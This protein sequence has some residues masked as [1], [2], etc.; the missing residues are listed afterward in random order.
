MADHPNVT[1]LRQG[2]EAFAKKDM[3]TLATLFSPDVVWHWTGKGPLAGIHRG[4]DAVFG[5]FGRMAMLC[6]DFRNHV[7]DI[8]ANDQHAV[9]LTQATGTRPGK[10]LDLKNVM[11]F[12]VQNEKVSEFWLYTE[13]Q[14]AEEEFWS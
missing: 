3:A 10:K 13:D 1:L 4:R 14:R 2:Y 7:R 11:T 12:S 8:V 5:I 6:P 9:A